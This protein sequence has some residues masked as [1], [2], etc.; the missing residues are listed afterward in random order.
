MSPNVGSVNCVG[1]AYIAY[2]AP[3][4]HSEEP[5]HH[6]D[7]RAALLDRAAERLQSDGLHALSLRSLA[8]ELGV[9]HAAPNRHFP[10]RQSFLDAL[11]AHGWERLGR[12]LHASDPGVDAG[13]RAR[14]LAPALA[15]VRFATS[16]PAL[17]EVMVAGKARSL[18][19]AADGAGARSWTPETLVVEG[20]R[21]G[22]LAGTDPT[23]I[24]TSFWS[25]LH[26]IS[27]LSISGM[28]GT[29]DLDVI[30]TRSVDLL[31]D[32]ARPR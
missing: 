16:Q 12:R 27:V 6:G 29:D 9:S 25:L 18:E 17:L 1:N 7:L 10:D 4:R 28:L 30:V 23:P 14:L 19:G 11:S 3:V 8:R 15:Y 21:T 13:L 20:Q 26:G 22:E 31:L 2:R 32:G 24:A 5:Y